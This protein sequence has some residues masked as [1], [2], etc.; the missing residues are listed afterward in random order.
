[1]TKNIFVL[2]LDDFNNQFLKRLRQSESYRFHPLLEYS[3]IRGQ[4][5]YPVTELLEKCERR[6]A[7]FEGSIDGIVA[8]FDFPVTIMVPLLCKELGLPAASPEAV[9]KCEHKYWSRIEQ[10]R[11]IKDYIPI[12]ETFD[13]FDENPQASLSLLYPF[14]IKPIKSFRSFLAYRI[15]DRTAFEENLGVIRDN[16][17]RISKPFDVLL[18]KIELPEDIAK[19]SARS[20]IAESLLSGAQCTL[21]G[22]VYNG[23]V[24]VYGVVD[25]IREADRSSFLA[26]QYPSQLPEHIQTQMKDIAERFMTHI[27]YDNATFNAEFFYN[28]TEDS[29]SLLEV[30]PRMS[31]SHAYLFESVDGVSNHQIMVDLAL[32]KE[33]FFPHGKGHY[34]CAAKFMLRSYEDGI[35]T[36]MPTEDETEKITAEIPGSQIELLINTGDRLSALQNQDSYSYELADVY[37]AGADRRDMIDKY[38]RFVEALEFGFI[39]KPKSRF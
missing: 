21:E 23:K 7:A 2:G 6:L 24:H 37:I 1:M 4:E 38:K 27:G 12:F 5:D 22:Y 35:V 9:L 20:C 14:W 13:P 33:P 19:I 10:L 26:Y 39:L 8:Y 11:V 36:R 17:E 30:N 15:N 34:N 25:S 31:Q 3:E 18:D 16:I 29:L 28:Q 32:G